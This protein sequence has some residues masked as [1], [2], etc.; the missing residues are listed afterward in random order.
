MI[1]LVET[2]IRAAIT[3][4]RIQ[5]AIKCKGFHLFQ[6]TTHMVCC[7]TLQC[8][9]TVIGESACADPN[10]FDLQLGQHYAQEDAERK[11]G[12]LLAYGQSY[13][14]AFGGSHDY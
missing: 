10:Q 4:Q 14:L 3:P 11:I 7:L 13:K 12:E 6:G 5:D 8:G 2:S 1:A 9:F